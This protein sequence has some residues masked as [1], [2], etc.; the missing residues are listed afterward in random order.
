GVAFDEMAESLESQATA[1]AEAAAEEA[2]LRRQVEG[3]MTSM[4]DGIVA[5]DLVGTITAANPAA[6]LMLGLDH[7]VLIGADVTDVIV[8]RDVEGRSLEDRLTAPAPAW[9]ARSELARP[10]GRTLPVVVS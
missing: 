8:G 3:V 4:R 5:V 10:D 2:R 7:D 9:S 6:E 1:L